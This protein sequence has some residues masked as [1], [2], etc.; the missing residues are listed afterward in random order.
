MKVIHPKT[1]PAA[2]GYSNGIVA[3]GPVL[4]VGGQIGWDGTTVVSDD[5]CEQFARALDNIIAVVTEAGGQPYDIVRMTIFVTD[6]S[7]YR[8]SAKPLGALWRARFGRHY[9]AMALVGV[10]GLVE[11]RALVEIEA[12]AVISS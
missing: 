7:T 5:F 4:Y 1:W 2:R 8:A 11:P 9:P 6:L 3:E 10:T 12:T